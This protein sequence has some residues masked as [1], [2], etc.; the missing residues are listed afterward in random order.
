MKF[1]KGQMVLFNN[2]YV[3]VAHCY[4]SFQD[5]IDAYAIEF[6]DGV[7]RLCFEDELELP[8]QISFDEFITK[9][10]NL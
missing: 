5:N 6:K 2:R 8:T 4:K 7:H 9:N 3:S 1:K 10:N